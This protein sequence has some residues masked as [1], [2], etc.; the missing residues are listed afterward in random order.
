MTSRQVGK[1]YPPLQNRI[2]DIPPLSFHSFTAFCRE[3][4][5]PAK[6]ISPAVHAL[7]ERPAWPGNA[8][9]LSG[10]SPELLPK[11]ARVQTLL[12]SRFKL[13]NGCAR[14]LDCRPWIANHKLSPKR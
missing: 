2:E 14:S 5:V 13:G 4:G 1:R 10:E 6:D 11:D 3:S 7:L 12:E 8:F 9:I